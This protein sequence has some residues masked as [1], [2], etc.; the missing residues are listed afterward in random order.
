MAQV[1]RKALPKKLRPPSTSRVAVAS[2][3]IYVDYFGFSYTPRPITTYSARRLL[4]VTPPGHAKV[5][6]FRW[7]VR[8]HIGRLG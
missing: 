5:E 4:R 2:R 1:I 7:M 6:S 3:L 8:R